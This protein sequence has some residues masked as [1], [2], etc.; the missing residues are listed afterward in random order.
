MAL[1]IFTPNNWAGYGYDSATGERGFVVKVKNGTG[2]NTVKG[3]LVACS[4]SADDTVILQ[5]NEFDTIGA[6]A[7]AGVANGAYFWMWVNGSI[8]QVRYKANTGSTHGN[9]LIADA[10]NGD[11]SD[12]TNPGGGLPGTDTHF[13]ECGHVLETKSAG[14]LGTYQLVLCSLHFN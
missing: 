9:I 14:G 7:E 12:I 5:A 3:Q 8:C 11:A 1:R 4:T 2:G 6:I 10:D 13:K